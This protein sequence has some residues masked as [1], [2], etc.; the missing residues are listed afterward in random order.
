MMIITI[1]KLMMI[2]TIITIITKSR[3]VFRVK[4]RLFVDDRDDRD[5]RD[6]RDDRDDRSGLHKERVTMNTVWT[7]LTGLGV[8]LLVVLGI[9]FLVLEFGVRALRRPSWWR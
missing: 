9:Y 8:V 7:V 4:G 3:V 5:Y 2:I 6:D 1:I